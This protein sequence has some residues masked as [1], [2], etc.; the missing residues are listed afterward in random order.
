L[1]RESGVNL[2][3][4]F[5]LALTLTCSPLILWLGFTFMTDV[6]FLGWMLIACWVYARG[7]RLGSTWTLFL[8]S[9]A[10]ALA[11]GTRQFGIALPIG[12]VLAE[13]MVGR[14]RRLPGIAIL[15]GITIP[16]AVF[17]WEL[18]L[19]S[20]H[21]TF[22]QRVRLVE[23]ELYLRQGGASLLLQTLWRG[24]VFTEYLGLFLVAVTPA[25]L[26]F[27]FQQRITSKASFLIPGC[28]SAA[29]VVAGHVLSAMWAMGPL[30]LR[31]KAA[32]APSISW[33]IGFV[34]PYGSRYQLARTMV[35]LLSGALCCAFLFRSSVLQ[36]A[37]RERDV[38][39][40]FLVATPV[41]LGILHLGYVQ[42]NDT[43]LI[44]FVPFALIGIAYLLQSQNVSASSIYSIG[45]CSAIL[46]LVVAG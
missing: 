45:L 35:G 21:P 30:L 24:A 19:T 27:I 11:V 16:C 4:S 2:S 43:Y 13:V 7:L 37:W 18:W 28:V 26:L 40:A 29:Y 8:G 22:T 46:G 41:A 6:Q 17:L 39:S 25:L 32:L 3:I 23:Q 20:Q 10:A 1:L 33:V 15:G 36:L 12:L 9:M 38:V 44:A 34:F 14:K 5:V 31:V 42:F